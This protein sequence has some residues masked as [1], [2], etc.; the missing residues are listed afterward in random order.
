MTNDETAKP[1][2]GPKPK[3]HILHFVGSKLYSPKAFKDE[4]QK[5]G[6]NRAFPS[7]LIKNAGLNFGDSVLLG[8]WSRDNTLN[9]TSHTRL[10]NARIWGKF[11]V[12]AFNVSATDRLRQRFSEL[13]NQE[14]PN[15]KMVSE[16]KL[17]TRQCGSYLLSATR[18]T[19][20]PLPAIIKAW[21]DAKVDTGEEGKMFL[22]GAYEDIQPEVVVRK[23]V[24]FSRAGIFVDYLETRLGNYARPSIGFIDNYSQVK[25]VKKGDRPKEDAPAPAPSAPSPSPVQGGDTNEQA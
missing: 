14:K 6:V 17:V 12:T 5:I 2:D 10:G 1:D 3:M 11:K 9:P 22:S 23:P 16:P 19:D 20:I 7:W 18:E 24:G 21:E 13:L 4:A 8:D 15:E 25:Y